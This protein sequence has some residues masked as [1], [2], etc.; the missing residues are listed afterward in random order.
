MSVDGGQGFSLLSQINDVSASGPGFS[1]DIDGGG[2]QFAAWP[3]PVGLSFSRSLDGGLSFGS[4]IQINDLWNDSMIGSP[5]VV[6]SPDN[7]NLNIISFNRDETSGY[8][9]RITW[10][11]DGGQS[12]G[13]SAHIAMDGAG[14]IFVLWPGIYFTRNR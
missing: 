2:K 12:F 14:D 8:N 6:K 5:P 4:S 13:T 1:Y 3:S 11:A 10:S 9:I 7:G